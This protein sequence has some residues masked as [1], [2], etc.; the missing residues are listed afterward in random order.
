MIKTAQIAIV[1]ANFCCVGQNTEFLLKDYSNPALLRNITATTLY[2][3]HSIINPQFDIKSNKIGSVYRLWD[4]TFHTSYDQYGYKQYK[5]Q[6]ITVSSFQKIS[7][8]V[9]LGLNINL[10]RAAGLGFKKHHSIS[11]DMGWNYQNKRY[12]IDL[13]IENPLNSAYV[14]ND[15]ESRVIISGLYRWTAHLQSI[16]KIEES[17]LTN[18]S[19]QHELKYVYE[20][21]FIVSLIHN[22]ANTQYGFSLGYKKEPFQILTTYNSHPWA[23]KLGFSLIYQVF[24][25]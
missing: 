16:L 21:A 2:T 1:L 13:F 5:E 25:G 24:D 11:F 20:N 10:H 19:R 14:K 9:Y 3:G 17:Y 12:E 6:K 18:S 15:I 4:R 23:N 22:F 8:N 7:T